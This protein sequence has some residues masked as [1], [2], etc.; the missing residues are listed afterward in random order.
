MNE[1]DPAQPWYH[2]SD[3]HLTMLR[4]GSSLR[5]VRLLKQT[6]VRPE[7]QCTPEQIAAIHRT[8]EILDTS[9]FLSDARPWD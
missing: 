8:Q 1:W 3:Q 2:G 5:R 4:V 6:V 9:S 7:E